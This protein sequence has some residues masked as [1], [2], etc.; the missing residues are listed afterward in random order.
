MRTPRGIVTKETSPDWHGSVCCSKSG[1]QGTGLR[2]GAYVFVMRSSLVPPVGT[3]CILGLMG[4]CVFWVT[5]P[6]FAGAAPPATR[7]HVVLGEM[8]ADTLQATPQ[9]VRPAAARALMRDH[10]VISPSSTDSHV[11]TEWK[12]FHH[13]LARLLVGQLRAR[14]VVDIQPLDE[15]LTIVRFQGGLAS[16]GSGMEENPV[17]AV[18]QSSYRGAVQDFYHDLTT[19][20]A[21]QR[22]ANSSD[23]PG[24]SRSR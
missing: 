6:V 24:S 19:G 11:V 2:L 13:P 22:A 7:P 20:I 18:A 12:D 1:N 15:R 5:A 17:F 10:W 14:C 9:E 21:E 23:A 3:L 16:P 8:R 4:V